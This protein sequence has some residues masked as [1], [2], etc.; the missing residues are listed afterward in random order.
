MLRSR[1]SSVEGRGLL[2]GV[3]RRGSKTDSLD[4][5]RSGKLVKSDSESGTDM[6]LSGAGGGGSGGQRGMGAASSIDSM[7]LFKS[8]K[9]SGVSDTESST[10]KKKGKK[11][12]VQK[13][14]GR[15]HVTS[16][17]RVTRM[18]AE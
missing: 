3:F 17:Y 12:A 13:V 7:D 16:A 11:K 14:R 4:R 1:D 10:G 9:S 15:V 8:A 6:G 5:D 18:V 2:G